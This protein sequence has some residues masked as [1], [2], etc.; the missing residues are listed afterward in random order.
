MRLGDVGRSP[1]SLTLST[2]DL[3]NMLGIERNAS[4][5]EVKRAYRSLARQWH[6]DHNP[7][8]DQA[9]LRFQDI[10]HAYRTL[11]HPESRARYDRLGPLYTDDGRPPKPEVVR[12]VAQTLWE[13]LTGRRKPPPGRDLHTEVTLTL[14]DLTAPS[15]PLVTIERLAWCGRCDARGSASPSGEAPCQVCQGSGRPGGPWLLRTRCYHCQGR[16]YAILQACPDCDGRCR[17]KMESTVRLT[18]PAGVA[19]G[20]SMRVAGQGDVPEAGQGATGH[21][22]V[23]VDIEEHSLFERRG[24]DL[25]VSLPLSFPELVFGTEATVPTLTGSSTIVITPGTAPGTRMKLAGKGLP[26]PQTRHRG[27]LHITVDLEIPRDMTREQQAQLRQWQEQL[28]EH[29]H[30]RRHAFQTT[31]RQRS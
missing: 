12:D 21:L 24:S 10:E 30:P 3:Y 7:G 29:A 2:H 11:S 9:T 18:I 19:P 4:L 25:H 8:D 5:A 16:G 6:P 31:T 22:Y 26:C 1:R 20:Q 28:S 27:D 15:E 14:E 13:N 23:R 17:L